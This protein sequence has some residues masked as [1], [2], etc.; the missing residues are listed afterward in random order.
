VIDMSKRTKIMI[1]VP[2][3]DGDFGFLAEHVGTMGKDC[4]I[5]EGVI[6]AYGPLTKIRKGYD[7]N[8]KIWLGDNVHIRPRSIIWADLRPMLP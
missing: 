4:N 7:P 5:E 1:F 3:E 8:A 2:T 6:L